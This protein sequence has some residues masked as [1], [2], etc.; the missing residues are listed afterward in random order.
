[1]RTIHLIPW[2]FLF[3]VIPGCSR[4]P[5]LKVTVVGPDGKPVAGATVT[6]VYSDAENKIA[7]TAKR[8][9]SNGEIV[10][11]G[12]HDNSDVTIVTKASGLTTDSR[13]FHVGSQT[14]YQVKIGLKK[15]SG[16]SSQSTSGK[17]LPDKA[18]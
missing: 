7:T 6:I 1:M 8:T 5:N 18:P 13:V 17:S 16:V 12:I 3:L 15:G 10:F 2:F 14:D 9:P 11:S 4:D